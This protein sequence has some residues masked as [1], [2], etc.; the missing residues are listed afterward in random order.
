MT[1]TAPR[2]PAVGSAIAAILAAAVPGNTANLALEL[3]P[4]RVNPIA[5][6]FVAQHGRYEC[7]SLERYL[8]PSETPAAGLHTATAT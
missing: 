3:A 2:H 1:G 5:A 4:I 8:Q 7:G 6:G